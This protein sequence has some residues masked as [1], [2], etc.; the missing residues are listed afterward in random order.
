MSNYEENLQTIKKQ[1]PFLELSDNPI[2]ENVLVGQDL[3]G[4]SILGY[5]E[6]GKE[7]LF[8]SRY[9]SEEIAEK[10][11]DQFETD[12]PYALF[13]I[14]G[15]ANG[16]YIKCLRRKFPDHVIIVYEPSESVFKTFLS[17]D[18][19]KEILELEKVCIAA[20]S[21]ALHILLEYYGE[22]LT[23][24]NFRLVQWGKTPGYVRIWPEELARIQ[25]KFVDSYEMRIL[26]RNTQIIHEKERKDNFLINLWDLIYQYSVSDLMEQFRTS[27][28]NQYPAIV[29]SAGPS[30]D[31]NILE[32]KNAKGK[33]FIIAVDAALGALNKAGIVPDFA[34]T[35]D[36]NKHLELFEFDDFEK[37]PLLVDISHNSKIN[38]LSNAKRFYMNSDEKYMDYL[39]ETYEKP[40][41]R[42]ESGGSVACLAFSLCVRSGFKEIILIGQDLAYPNGKQHASNTYKDRKKIDLDPSKTYFEVDDIFGGKVLTERNMNFYRKWFENQIIRYNQ[43]HVTDATEGGAKIEGAEIATLK[44]TIAKKCIEEQTILF[45][46]LLQDIPTLFSEK[47]QAKIIEELHQLRGKLDGFERR[48]EKGI[49]NYESMNRLKKQG[50]TNEKEFK[51]AYKEI[52]EISEWAENNSDLKILEFYGN[53]MDYQI[54]DEMLMVS[55]DIEEEWDNTIRLGIRYLENMKASIDLLRKDFPL[56]LGEE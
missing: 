1:F 5:Y 37:I 55:S 6:S 53:C 51:K 3:T 11:C 19:A 33:A 43:I 10:W 13:M 38:K 36:P 22:L 44:D 56:L 28:F 34:V 25:R 41:G 7:F 45:A 16:D 32:L 21:I 20:G 35:V 48:V 30:L 23:Y 54:Q 50:R 2:D 8:N 29:V 47:Q 14:Y 17:L 26:T 12:N 15:I 39:F 31:K 27:G 18:E 49:R 46:D 42:L 52:C 24:S 40:L 9:D 4:K